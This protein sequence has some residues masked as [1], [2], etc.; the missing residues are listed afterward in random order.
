MHRWTVPIL[1]L[2]FALGTPT[3]SA[4]APRAYDLEA[5]IQTALSHH[6]SLRGAAARVQA[7]EAQLRQARAGYA[8]KLD[9]TL[10][11]TQ[12]DRDPYF[13]MAPIGRIVFGESEN[14]QVSVMAQYP[15]FTGGK[16]E[17]FNRQAEAGVR[18]SAEALA[19][20][21]Q[22]VTLDAATAYYNVL[23]AQRMVKVA[24]DQLKALK[25][26]RDAIAKM[27]QHGVVTR[28][29]LLRADTGV[30]GAQ[31]F[32]TRARNGEALATAALANAM[33]LPADQPLKVVAPPAARA[34]KSRPLPAGVDGA[35]REALQQRP[36]LRRLE[37][38]YQ[39]ASAA[40]TVAKSGAK[41]TLGLFA[42][43]DY[44]RQTFMPEWGDWSAGVML[45]MNVFD[46][47]STRADVARARSLVAQVEAGRDELR[48][49]IRLQVTQAFLNVQSAR[50]RVDTAK[51]AVAT[52]EEGLRL[53]RLGYQNGVNT[54]TDFLAAQAE[55]TKARTSYETAV[56]D[57]HAAE[58]ALRFA[59]GRKPGT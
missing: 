42:Q 7:S 14:K 23:N 9:A 40:V 55:L 53:V 18:I 41:P 24:E 31:E 22:K 27:L 47:G 59:L 44:K 13:T 29:D 36:E 46:G 11:W 25:S 12:L 4:P 35:I 16:L 38:N 37:A 54:I 52:A 56:F 26:Q 28:I 45:K 58:A 32:L 17:G 39:A 1:T 48:N 6:P 51:K 57:E 3:F 19:R 5:V 50:K 34:G 33:G 15:L 30:S 21:R 49:G 8:P 20:K 2:L 43:W 10:S